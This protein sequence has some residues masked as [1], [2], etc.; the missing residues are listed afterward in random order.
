MSAKLSYGPFKV[1][2]VQAT[3]LLILQCE[4]GDQNLDLIASVKQKIMDLKNEVIKKNLTY[5]STQVALIVTLSRKPGGT[6]FVGF[7]GG[8]WKSV[9]IDDLL[10]PSS[11]VVSVENA[12][13]VKSIG[14]L[15]LDKSLYNKS[16]RSFNPLHKIR[17]RIQAAVS[18]IQDT[19]EHKERIGK[20]IKILLN[21]MPTQPSSSQEG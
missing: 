3:K 5:C 15:L 14:D 4:F 1:L 18:C 20:R 13:S 9:Y 10:P 16:D 7:Q 12:T 17:T 2:C 6:R 11:K 8:Q 21:L 19:N